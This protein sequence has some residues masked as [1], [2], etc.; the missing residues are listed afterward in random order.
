M[1]FG[2]FDAWN[3]LELVLKAD[4]NSCQLLMVH[5]KALSHLALTSVCLH[6][7]H[8]FTLYVLNLNGI[9]ECVCDRDAYN[10]SDA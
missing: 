5:D 4:L 9:Y 2:I 7:E 1:P 10:K 6:L 8:A 3:R